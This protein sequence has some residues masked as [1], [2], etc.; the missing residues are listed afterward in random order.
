MQTH[1]DRF[2]QAGFTIVAERVQVVTFVMLMMEANR[3]LSPG[4]IAGIA[5]ALFL[6]ILSII[7]IVVL[8][9]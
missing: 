7:V 8:I 2:A 1:S 6:V 4:A 9:M 3:G 5:I